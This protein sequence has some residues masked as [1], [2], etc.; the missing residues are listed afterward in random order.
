MFLAKFWMVLASIGIAINLI[1]VLTLLQMAP[2]LKIIAQILPSSDT[3][4]ETA[5]YAQ[6][7][8]LPLKGLLSS[9]SNINKNNRALLD[10]MFVRYYLDMRL[11]RFNDPAEMLYRWVGVVRRLSAPH[12]Y[13]TFLKEF[14]EG[15]EEELKKMP[16][17]K[18]T[19]SID[20]LSVS[21]IGKI[22]SVEFNV[23]QY[24]PLAPIPRPKVQ[25]RI[26]TI[27][28]AHR[29]NVHLYNTQETN[30]YGFYIKNYR[31]TVKKK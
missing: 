1:I 20:I 3:T 21:S 9:D 10:E 8:T 11:S 2:K 15:I 30:P 16:E 6:I 25:R 12:V 17:E 14:K 23:F 5:N 7:D 19:R 13:Y 22:Y 27:E 29:P 28:I 24:D 4:K 31:E 26:A 18:E